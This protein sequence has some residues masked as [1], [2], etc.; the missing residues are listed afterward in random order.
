MNHEL[1]LTLPKSWHELSQR[2]LRQVYKAIASG[3]P[4][5]DARLCIAMRWAGLRPTRSFGV[6]RLSR[7]AIR[8]SK[9]DIQH[10]TLLALTASDLHTLADALSWLDTLPP[11]PSRPEK[12]A[13]RKA[14][15][16]LLYE[17]DF[18][19]FLSLDNLFR[20]YHAKK[21]PA[22]LDRMFKILYPLPKFKIPHP[23]L[24]KGFRRTVVL[25]WFAS[26]KQAFARLFPNFLQP[27]T[28]GIQQPSSNPMDAV[29]TM[30]R[31]LTKGDIT[32]EE[33]IRKMPCHRA[34]TELD[35]LARE[36]EQLRRQLKK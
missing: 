20:G 9:S 27:T 35:A 22:L 4:S 34:L 5:L 3:L 19:T 36:S 25:Y 33:E 11:T 30:L 31:A 1:N 12:I 29:N 21:D 2:Q 23:Q 15:S 10:S 24:S 13:G 17:V 18:E 16:P 26:L 6:F 28:S 14:L 32:K 7:S 8:N